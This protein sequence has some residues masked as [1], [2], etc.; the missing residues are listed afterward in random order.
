[1]HIFIRVVTLRGKFGST[2]YGGKAAHFPHG[3]AS[4][5]SESIPPLRPGRTWVMLQIPSCPSASCPFTHHQSDKI[6]IQRHCGTDCSAILL[7]IK[8]NVAEA[9]FSGISK[10]PYWCELPCISRVTVSEIF[11]ALMKTPALML[12]FW[13]C[14]NCCLAT[15]EVVWPVMFAPTKMSLKEWILQIWGFGLIGSGWEVGL[16]ASQKQR[17]LPLG[18]D[19]HPDTKENPPKCGFSGIFETSDL[20]RCWT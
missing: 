11:Y 16:L 1:M 14:I 10:G 5:F 18:T 12:R 8:S 13:F 2:G 3:K 20:G 9:V 15:W 4:L 19:H 7:E 6:T 17:K